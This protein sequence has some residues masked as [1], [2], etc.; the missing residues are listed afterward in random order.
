MEAEE[1]QLAATVGIHV[2]GDSVYRD[3]LIEDENDRQRFYF[4]RYVILIC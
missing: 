3:E 1:E 4:H 2:R